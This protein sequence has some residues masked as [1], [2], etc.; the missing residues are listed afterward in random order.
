MFATRFSL[1]IEIDPNNSMLHFFGIT[2]QVSKLAGRRR[3]HEVPDQ[4]NDK[5]IEIK[6]MRTGEFFLERHY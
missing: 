6:A 4:E 2:C 3:N 5:K 1:S